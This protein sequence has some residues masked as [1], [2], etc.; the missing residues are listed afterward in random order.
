MDAVTAVLPPLLGRLRPRCE[1]IVLGKVPLNSS[2]GVLSSVVHPTSVTNRDAR[3]QTQPVATTVELGD[4]HP[5][6]DSDRLS[7]DVATG[8][9]RQPDHGRRDLRQIAHAAED[10]AGQQ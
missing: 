6:V 2:P 8:G 10:H 5:A 4:G 1:P 7:G 9:G 3:D